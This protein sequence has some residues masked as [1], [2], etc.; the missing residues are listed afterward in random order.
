MKTSTLWSI[1]LMLI[2]TF[3]LSS[4]QDEEDPSLW[5]TPE[6]LIYDYQGKGVYYEIF[7]IKSNEAWTIE[8]QKNWIHLDKTSGEGDADISVAVDENL[9]KD[10]RS[11]TITITSKSGIKAYVTVT[12]EVYV[13][14][15]Q[16]EKLFGEWE[17]FY[18]DKDW[19]DNSKVRMSMIFY[20]TE[21]INYTYYGSMYSDLDGDGEET[22]EGMLKGTY[23]MI[24]ANL[25]FLNEWSSM[26]SGVELTGYYDIKQ[27]D[28]KSFIF[29]RQNV[30]LTGRKKS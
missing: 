4:C 12:Q 24:S 9:K 21:G 8:C 27:L 29:T 13:A 15:A 19:N 5:V 7:N 23:D 28:D 30:T 25:I 11:A 17:V 18:T 22:D 26:P 16:P 20:Q 10:E 3:I 6:Q 2:G 14:P 1:L